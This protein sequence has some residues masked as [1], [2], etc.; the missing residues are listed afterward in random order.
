MTALIAVLEFGGLVAAVLGILFRMRGWWPE[1][2]GC[3]SVV[4]SCALVAA[5][6]APTE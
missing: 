5:V 1:I 4:I 3:G 6:W 2:V